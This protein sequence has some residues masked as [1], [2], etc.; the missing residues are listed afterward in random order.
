MQD[1]MEMRHITK[2]VHHDT[3]VSTLKRIAKHDRN[4]IARYVIDHHGKL[5]AGSASEHCHDDIL[6]VKEINAAVHSDE[7]D[8]GLFPN[9]A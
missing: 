7:K 5:H 1:L 6:P 2:D 9:R 8:S 4:G 3:S